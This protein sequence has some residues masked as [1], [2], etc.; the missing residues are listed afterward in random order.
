MTGRWKRLWTEVAACAGILSAQAQTDS[1]VEA[2]P[3]FIHQIEAEGRPAYIFPTTSFL[4]GYNNQRLI[5]KGGASYHLRYAFRFADWRK[6]IRRRD[7]YQGVGVG[8]FD[9]RNKEGLGL[10]TAVYLFQGAPVARFSRNLSWNY[11]WNLGLAWGWKPYDRVLNP[12]NR[13]IGSKVNAYLNASMYL[14]WRLSPHWALRLGMEATHFSNG[15]TSYPNLGLNTAGGRIGLVY[16]VNPPVGSLPALPSLSSSFKKH[17]TYDALLF[18]SWRRTGMRYPEG[19][20]LAPGV[21]PVA[22]F[23]FSPLYAFHPRWKAGVSLDGVYDGGSMIGGDDHGEGVVRPPFR[24]QLS[25]GLSGRVEYTMPFFSIN[26]GF[27][28]NFLNSNKELKLFYQTLSLKIDITHGL[29]LN[30]GYNL[31]NFQEPNYL[32]LGV[33]ICV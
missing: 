25:L 33:G 19:L 29:Y 30:I 4:K 17:W 26:V 13:M 18:G 28:G 5:M 1:A 2:H 11:E 14:H 15:N 9:F 23:S 32:M 8:L 20:F 7:L 22:G 10:P 24:K 31:K 6:D 12:T 27:G 21:Y 16:T 3:R